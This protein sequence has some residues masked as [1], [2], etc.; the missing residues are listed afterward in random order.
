MRKKKEIF[1]EWRELERWVG[2]KDKC[3]LLHNVL[4]LFIADNY[5]YQNEGGWTGPVVSP[6]EVFLNKHCGPLG[7]LSEGMCPA[8]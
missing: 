4:A 6:L 2:I 1:E 8:S 7:T 5:L 3:R